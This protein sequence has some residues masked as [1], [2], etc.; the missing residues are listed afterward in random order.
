[1]LGLRWNFVQDELIF[2]LNELA[3]SVK[4][5]EPTKRQIVAITTKFYDPLGF[6]SP[7]IIRFKILFQA[8]CIHK[9]G[10]DEPLTGA[11]LSQWRSLVSTFQGMSTS[12]PRCYFVLS[13][14]LSSTCQLQG[15]CD[16]SSGAYA[17]VVYL[18]IESEAGNSVNFVASRT[19][20]APTAKQTIPRLELLSALLLSRLISNV[21]VALASEVDLKES[22]CYTDSKVALYWIMGTEKEWKPFVE[23]RVTEIRR[24]VP[25]TS[26]SHCSGR[27]NPADLPSRGMTPTKLVGSKLWR[28]G[29]EWLVHSRSHIDENVEMPDECLKEIKISPHRTRNLLMMS[30]QH[31]LNDVIHCKEYSSLSRLLRITAYVIRFIDKLNP[32]VKRSGESDCKSQLTAHEIGRAEVC[33]IKEA[34]KSLL[35]EPTFKTWKQQ[36]GL[37]LEDGV[38]RC[39]GRLHNADIP[40]TTRYPAL[41]PKNHHLTSLIIWDCHNKVMHNGVKETLCELRSRFEA[42]PYNIPPSPPLPSFRVTEKPAFTHTGVDFAGPLYVKGLGCST[43][44]LVPDMSCESFIRSFKRFTARRGFPH[45][46][47]SDNGKT[48]KSAAK[49]IANVLNHPEVLQ[50]FT[51]VGV[52][53]SFNLEKAPWWGGIF[54][55]MVKS[56]KRCLRKIIGQARLTHDELLTALTE[57]EMIINSRPLSYVS[58]EDCE[59]PLTPSHL[60][61]GRRVLSLPDSALHYGIDEDV[62]FTQEA[63][64]RRMDHLNKTLNHFWKRW[65]M[66]YLLELRESHRYGPKTDPKNNSPS[67]GDVVLMLILLQYLW[68]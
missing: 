15:F 2:D 20:V 12:I 6:I 53:W 43:Q 50:F 9:I 55:R 58:T 38:W 61:I 49:T 28:Y 22:H 30:N 21:S 59:E 18:R 40:Y 46:V 19:R 4:G 32:R 66:E 35:E 25:P 68:F 1:M 24:L 10:W 11:L 5:I 48:F 34:Q 45:Q 37:F 36:L 44:N 64:T 8:M 16:A 23:N 39:K 41:L 27:E 62:E 51:G 57:V 56:V 31:S 42:Q 47:I 3:M 54:E 52:Q 63:L 13:E 29:P 60:L 26:W 17:A 33:W 65:K 14:R 7:V 67:E